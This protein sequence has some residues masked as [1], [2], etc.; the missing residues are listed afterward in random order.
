MVAPPPYARSFRPRRRGLSAERAEMYEQLLAQ[1]TWRSTGPC[2]SSPSC[3]VRPLRW[4][5]T[6]GS[7]VAKDSST[8][9][10][11]DLHEYLIGVE[12]HTPG[13][14]KVLEAVH[15]HGWRHVRVVEGDAR[16]LPA[17]TGAGVT[18]RCANLVPRPV[19]ETETAAS[20]PRA[21]RC[22]RGA[23]R[24][25]VHRWH[26]ACGHRHRRLCAA[27]SIGGSGG[28]AWRV[29]WSPGRN[30]ALSRR[31]ERTRSCRRSYPDRPRLRENLLEMSTT[32]DSLFTARRRVMLCALFGG[33]AGLVFAFLG[34][35]QLAVL[36]GWD[37]MAAVLLVW[38]WAE[39]GPAD[40]AATQ[41]WSGP[42]DSSH[43]AALVVMTTASVVSLAGMAMGLIKARQSTQAAR[44]RAHR[45]GGAH[46]GAL[47]VRGAH[48]VHAA[49]R[50]PVLP[51]PCGRYQLPHRPATR[52][53]RLRLPR[54]HGRYGIRR[55][56]HR[57][58]G[59]PDPTYVHSTRPLVSYL[60]G[61]VIVG[62][63][64]NVMAG[65]VR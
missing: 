8:W 18:R 52:L 3:S 25:A 43:A 4:C 30:G 39:I 44:G 16:R 57:S 42:E 28:T 7:G 53:P 47:V 35:W 59:S 45:G 49:V 56:R 17:S 10:R 50:G 2:S 51:R 32:S 5:S 24:S 63:T 62:L 6:S 12:V 19:A 27:R 40:A 58:H 48:D 15:E 65:F 13:V 21:A 41:R 1:W 29:G 26:P 38:I 46:R 34:P 9:P 22:G 64:I 33:A 36:I 61:A 37:S 20:S 14:A 55:Q 11:Y 54:V 60:F 31:F 23:H